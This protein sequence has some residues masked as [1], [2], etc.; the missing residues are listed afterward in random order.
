MR[1]KF[2]VIEDFAVISLRNGRNVKIDKED[3]DRVSVYSWHQNKRS[4]GVPGY[5]RSGNNSVSLHQLI[6]GKKEGYEVDHINRDVLDNRK[7]NLRFV[8]HSENMRN[9][10]TQSNNKSG[11]R[12][13]H[14]HKGNKRWVALI[15]LNNKQI[16]LG[17]FVNKEDAIRARKEAENKYFIRD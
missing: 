15:G 9:A 8:T 1:S 4:G 5:I 2:I 7:A 17:S 14:W 12:G 10:K 13:V 6:L 3:L 16:D 11:C